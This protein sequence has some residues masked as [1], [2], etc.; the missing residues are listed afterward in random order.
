MFDTELERTDEELC[1]QSMKIKY[2]KLSKNNK[3]QLKQC[4]ITPTIVVFAARIILL[5]TKFFADDCK[6]L[7]PDA[8]LLRK[9]IYSSYRN[10]YTNS[11]RT[12]LQLRLFYNLQKKMIKVFKILKKIPSAVLKKNF[13]RCA[14]DSLLTHVMNSNGALFPN[15][16]LLTIF[17]LFKPTKLEPGGD[18]KHS[19]IPPCFMCQC[20]FTRDL[21]HAITCNMAGQTIHVQNNTVS[22]LA[23]EA[24]LNRE[25][26]VV[27]HQ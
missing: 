7:P 4:Q 10:V 22:C 12:P 20:H 19:I 15:K 5:N 1:N 21:C 18:P 14:E 8:A 13:I 9:N 24:S 23:H 11:T 2:D 3:T 16:S 17:S 6:R 25:D 26:F 27:S